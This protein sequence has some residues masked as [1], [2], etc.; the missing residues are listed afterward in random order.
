MKVYQ[1]PDDMQ[2][3]RCISAGN[4]DSSY[5]GR[6]IIELWKQ[7]AEPDEPGYA[8]S[9]EKAANLDQHDW[10]RFLVIPIRVL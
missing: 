8:Y 4:P 2:G 3:K 10:L 5:L 1:L 7:P 6:I 9:Y